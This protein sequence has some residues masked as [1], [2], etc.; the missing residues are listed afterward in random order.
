[1]ISLHS[2]KRKHDEFASKSGGKNKDK[3]MNLTPIHEDGELDEMGGFD[4]GNFP[5]IVTLDEDDDDI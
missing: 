1:M 5:T 4:S 3:E 2:K